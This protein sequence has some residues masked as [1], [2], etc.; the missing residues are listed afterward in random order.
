M[1]VIGIGNPLMRDDGAGLSVIDL[2][3]RE[4]KNVAIVDAGTGGMMLL[5]ILPD[6]DVA[7]IV[8]A[9]DFGGKPGEIRTFPLS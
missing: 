6:L 5:H 7:V 1:A 9:V 8:D 2:L 3:S 4:P